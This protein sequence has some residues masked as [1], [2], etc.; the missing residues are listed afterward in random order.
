VTAA[1][2]STGATAD[3]PDRPAAERAR[4]ALLSQIWVV[5]RTTDAL[6]LLGEVPPGTRF[7][8]RTGECIGADGS[9]ELGTGAVG[10]GLVTQRSELRA[11]E[12]R[13]AICLEEAEAAQ[14]TIDELQARVDD[15]RSATRDAQARR[16]RAAETIAGARHEL[17][18]TVRERAAAADGV[19]AAEARLRVA[20]QRAA[21]ETAGVRIAV[22]ATTT[23]SIALDTARAEVTAAEAAVRA[24]AQARDAIDD[25]IQQLRIARATGGEKLARGQETRHGLTVAAQDRAADVATARRVADKAARPIA[26]GPFRR[27][28]NPSVAAAPNVVVPSGLY[29]PIRPIVATA[30]NTTRNE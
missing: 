2:A 29:P 1:E 15:L 11:L 6:A 21:E 20:E 23:G 9:F 5:E 10:S 3:G 27:A 30:G 22:E 28:F 12:R 25:E 24:L 19:A 13:Q 4:T 8:A 7:L 16:A 17:T 18:R 14:R 26:R